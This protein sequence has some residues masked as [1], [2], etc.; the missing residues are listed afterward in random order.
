[1]VI[2]SIDIDFFVAPTKRDAPPNPTKRL[3]HERYAVDHEHEIRD[4]LEKKCQLSRNRRI[5]GALIRHHV[6]GF[7]ILESIFLSTNRPSKLVHVD[8]H[9]DLGVGDCAYSYLLTDWLHEPRD[10]RPP[11]KRGDDGLNLG[12]WLAFAAA[13]GFVESVEFIPRWYPP[14]YILQCYFDKDP[15]HAE[16]MRFC[17]ISPE[18]LSTNFCQ[19]GLKQWRSFLRSQEART[20]VSWMITELRNFAMESHPDFVFFCQSPAYTPA[21]AD[22][23]LEMAKEYIHIDTL[24]LT[25]VEPV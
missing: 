7:D 25:L 2:L 16:R 11:P 24:G 15:V 19:H 6:Q 10:K 13:A 20:T 1:M 5:P 22:T 14:S 17:P 8:A 9:D 18:D 3:C 21:T 12:N 4:F 23:I